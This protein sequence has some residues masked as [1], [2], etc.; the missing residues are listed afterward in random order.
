MA[1]PATPKKIYFRNTSNDGNFCRLCAKLKQKSLFIKIFSNIGKNKNIENKISLTCG[2]RTT[3]LDALPTVIC[4]SCVTML[5]L[6]AD[7]S[8]LQKK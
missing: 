2:L 8:N 1:K 3:E 4:Q 7:N 6:T 5:T